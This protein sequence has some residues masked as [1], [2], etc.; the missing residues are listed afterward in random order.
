MDGQFNLGNIIAQFALLMSTAILIEAGLSFL[1]FGIQPPEPAW[2]SMLSY[3]K[4]YVSHSLCY[5]AG[6][7]LMIFGVVMSINTIGDL[8]KNTLNPKKRG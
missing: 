1:G 4:K 5:I 2:G 7:T 3:A 6:P 8:L